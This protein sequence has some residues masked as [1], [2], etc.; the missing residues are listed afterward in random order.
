M[1]GNIPLNKI[2]NIPYPK[3][4]TEALDHNIHAAIQAI[5]AGA[6]PL[7]MTPRA[8]GKTPTQEPVT[9]DVKLRTPLKRGA[10]VGE[11]SH[12]HDADFV[13]EHTDASGNMDPE[14]ERHLR[15][16]EHYAIHTVCIGSATK[17]RRSSTGMPLPQYDQ[18]G[19]ILQQSS[20]GEYRL[21]MVHP[22]PDRDG[23]ATPFPIRGPNL[24]PLTGPDYVQLVK[25]FCDE[26]KTDPTLKFED[27]LRTHVE[28]PKIDGAV[29]SQKKYIKL[30]YQYLDYLQNGGTD[31][32]A[33]F[34]RNRTPNPIRKAARQLTLL[35]DQAED[36]RQTIMSPI[37]CPESLSR[38]DST[39]SPNDPDLF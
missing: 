19:I 18:D 32:F 33:D 37:P 14:L 10:P 6:I 15:A 3:Q 35:D 31:P 26:R 1:S 24:I 30:A 20:T 2:G 8:Q 7:P 21:F 29:F 11:T 16:R 28:L 39:A 4:A 23:N 27:F 38:I 25:D 22:A 12:F 5:A 9:P 34:L 17:K 13:D 36:A